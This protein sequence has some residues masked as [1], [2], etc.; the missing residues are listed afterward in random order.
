MIEKKHEHANTEHKHQ[1]NTK[2]TFDKVDWKL[3]EHM[4]NFM[5]KWF[6]E[7]V[8]NNKTVKDVLWSKI[9]NDMD[10][11][12][13]PYLKNIFTILWRIS[14][15]GWIFWL[16]S[17]LWALGLLFRRNFWLIFFVSALLSI[18][19]SLVSLVAWYWMIKFKKRVLLLALLEIWLSLLCFLLTILLSW[20][21][22]S[23]LFNVLFSAIFTIIIVK[24]RDMFKN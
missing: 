2:R 16:L 18:V 24:N 17:W 10:A 22:W 7:K 4:N 6:V 13:K 3:D 5:K 1:S 21:I 11:K 15:I 14:I 8:L 9:A 19:F 23:T 12:L 20:G